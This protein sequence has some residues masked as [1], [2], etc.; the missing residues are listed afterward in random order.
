MRHAP[1]TNTSEN[2]GGPTSHHSHM[3]CTHKNENQFLIVQRAT[4]NSVGA[5]I[6][7]YY[8]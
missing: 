1:G 7:F 3:A 4:P 6:I 5:I 2:A 8:E